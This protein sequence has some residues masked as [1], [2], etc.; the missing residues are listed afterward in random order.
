VLPTRG[1]LKSGQRGTEKTDLSNEKKMGNFL[2]TLRGKWQKP[3]WT[4]ILD[5]GLGR[6][7]VGSLTDDI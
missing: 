5:G 7:F 6:G 3:S 1:D 2:R 4:H